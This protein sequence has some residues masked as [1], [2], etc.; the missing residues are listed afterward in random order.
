MTNNELAI[1]NFKDVINTTSFRNRAAACLGKNADAFVSSMLDLYTGDIYLQN[2]NPEAVALECLKAASLK[3]PL[4]KNLGFACVVPRKNIPY[5]QIM[6]RGYVQLAMR[7]GQY[8]IINSD[9]IYEGESVKRDRLTGQLEIS[10]TA[11]S[12]VAIGYFAYFKLINGYEKMY[13]MTKDEVISHAD[14][15]SDSFHRS[16]SAWKTEF[17]KMARKTV[18]RQLLNYG[19]MSTEM[20]EAMKMDVLSAETAAKTEIQQNANTGDV[21][22]V[23]IVDLDT[24]EVISDGN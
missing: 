2:C 12:D 24:G 11:T 4:N 23:P 7:T 13:Y 5:F 21:I 6:W 15:Y 10:G 8:K 22:D 9:C 18:L 20:Q 14:T 16:N 17:D 3:L 1:T 19:P